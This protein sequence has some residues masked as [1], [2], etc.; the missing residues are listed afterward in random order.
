M[1][2]LEV[3]KNS[4]FVLKMIYVVHRRKFKRAV[5]IDA[6][7][8]LKRVHLHNN[9]AKAFLYQSNLKSKIL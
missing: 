8:S 3:C 4:K 6:N 9:V 5:N 1:R 7:M 2:I